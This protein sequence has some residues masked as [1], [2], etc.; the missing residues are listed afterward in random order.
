M[1][2]TLIAAAIAATLGTGAAQ[3]QQTYKLAFIDPLSSTPRVFESRLGLAGI[4][5]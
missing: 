4:A 5:D 1:K 2:S 3:A